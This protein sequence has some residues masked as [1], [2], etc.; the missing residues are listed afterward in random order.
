MHGSAIDSFSYRPRLEAGKQLTWIESSASPVLTMD[1]VHQES[2]SVAGTRSVSIYDSDWV[3][4]AI[5]V[6]Y[7]SGAFS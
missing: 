4:T 7:S 3:Y 1:T 2:L 5:F 6:S